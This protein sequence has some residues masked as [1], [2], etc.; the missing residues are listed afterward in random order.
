MKNYICLLISE[1][2]HQWWYTFYNIC[3]VQK[4]PCL[5]ICIKEINNDNDDDDNDN[6]DDYGDN[7]MN[8]DGDDHHI[9]KLYSNSINL[10][11]TE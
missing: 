8:D 1:F 6:H 9:F 4:Y 11:E 10:H 5:D 7:K 3:M 2:T